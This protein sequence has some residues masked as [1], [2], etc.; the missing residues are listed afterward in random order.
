MHRL[1]RFESCRAKA[2]ALR[3]DCASR[4]FRLDF[5]L[6]AGSPVWSSPLSTISRQ[7]PT[8]RLNTLLGLPARMREWQL[9]CLL[10]KAEQRALPLLFPI[11]EFAWM[12]AQRTQL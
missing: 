7:P 10:Q 6:S 4:V 1:G 5:P 8:L 12:A 9:H 2:T 11:N 3:L